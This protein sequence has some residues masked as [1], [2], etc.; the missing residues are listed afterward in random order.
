MATEFLVII[1]DAL[2]LFGETFMSTIGTWIPAL[3]AVAIQHDKVEIVVHE[4]DITVVGVEHHFDVAT[5]EFWKKWKLGVFAKQVDRQ[6]ELSATEA[7]KIGKYILHNWN[8]KNKREENS[9]ARRG[10]IGAV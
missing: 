8:V 7:G 6:I 3:Q 4:E 9:R 2:K 10:R 5:Q 1:L